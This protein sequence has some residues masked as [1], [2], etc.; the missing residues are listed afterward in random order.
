M[1]GNAVR[2]R[3]GYHIAVTRRTAEDADRHRDCVAAFGLTVSE[4]KTKIM[5]RKRKARE[6]DRS[7]LSLTGTAVGQ[8]CNHG[9]HF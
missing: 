8:V 4:A 1:V 6:R 5:R 9:L 7:L 3:R 2:R